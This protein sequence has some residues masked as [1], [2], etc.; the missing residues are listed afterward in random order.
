MVYF[1]KVESLYSQKK[2][3]LEMA[4]W[5]A[6]VVVPIKL[7]SPHFYRYKFSRLFFPLPKFAK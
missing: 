5:R 4:Q 7:F 6:S 3:D 1:F 2:H